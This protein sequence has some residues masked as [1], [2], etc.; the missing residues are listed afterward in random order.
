[1]KRNYE[2]KW[3][4]YQL[5]SSWLHVTKKYLLS[6]Q[7]A[8]CYKTEHNALSEQYHSHFISWQTPHS[9]LFLQMYS[10]KQVD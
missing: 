7:K 10:I 2:T 1:M 4:K 8:Q 3:K 6:L 5:Y 9:G